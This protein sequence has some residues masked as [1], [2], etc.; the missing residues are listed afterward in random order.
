MQNDIYAYDRRK[1]AVILCVIGI[2]TVIF[3]STTIVATA[4]VFPPLLPQ[5]TQQAPDQVK[6][7]EFK[8]A[9]LL[10]NTKGRLG[11]YNE[12]ITY[13]DKAL[14]INPN[15]VYALTSKGLAVGGLGKNN[16]SITY[17]DKALAINP[18]DVYALSSKGLA[19]ARLG[20][21]NEAISYYDKALTINPNSLVAIKEKEFT[22][23]AAAQNTNS[24]NTNSTL[25]SH[26]ANSWVLDTK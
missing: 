6:T 17:F 20:K 14:A 26:K 12:S 9:A 3:L 4:I 1:L 2:F 15:D 24:T 18:N 11:T 23:A 22:L 5:N 25:E 13:F 16:E 21:Y 10:Y 7:L 19:L 8:G